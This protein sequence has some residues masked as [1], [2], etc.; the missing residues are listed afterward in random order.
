MH[1][2]FSYGSCCR[3]PSNWPH[4]LIPIYFLNDTDTVLNLKMKLPLLKLV[5][6]VVDDDKDGEHFNS[7]KLFTPFLKPIH[8]KRDIFL[9]CNLQWKNFEFWN[10]SCKDNVPHAAPTYSG[11]FLIQWYGSTHVLINGSNKKLILPLISLRNLNN[12]SFREDMTFLTKF[13]LKTF[14]LIL[15]ALVY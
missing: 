2:W 6:V 11:T 15:Y 3:K 4:Y 7:R 1:W 8:L 13:H 12:Y 14:L 5:I 10:G 9:S